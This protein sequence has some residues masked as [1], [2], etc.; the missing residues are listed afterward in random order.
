MKRNRDP[1]R[2]VGIIPAVDNMNDGCTD[3]PTGLEKPPSEPVAV[4]GQTDSTTR[5]TM[6]P[7]AQRIAIA[8]ACGWIGVAQDFHGLTPPNEKKQ[9][10]ESVIPN[11]LS[12]LNA[13]HAAVQSQ[14]VEFRCRFN[15]GL[16]DKAGDKCLICD[17]TSKDWADIFIDISLS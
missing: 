1:L 7:E 11:Y 5:L 4:S 3:L 14:S 8:E 17:L 6:S 13:M 2:L 16:H 15:A 9:R 10:F 12:D